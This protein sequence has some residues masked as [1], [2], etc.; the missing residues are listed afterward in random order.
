MVLDGCVSHSQD[1]VST[2]MT[3]SLSYESTLNQ[4]FQW[5]NS[6]TSCAFHGHDLPTIFDSLIDQADQVPVAAP[7]CTGE[8]GSCRT[9]ATGY[10]ILTNVQDSL[11]YQNSTILASLQTWSSL[12]EALLAAVHGNATALSSRI[13]SATDYSGIAIGCQDW[14]RSPASYLEVKSKVLL[15]RTLSPHTRGVSQSLGYQTMCIGWPAPVSNP[16]QLL[17]PLGNLLGK[18][19]VLLVNSFH[20]PQTSMAWAL[21]LKDEMANSVAVY[22]DGSGHTSYVLGGETQAVIDEFLLEGTIPETGT[23]YAN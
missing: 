3:E 18:Q 20:D 10:E 8:T 16:Q 5:C 7:G 23:V 22:R 21:S 9:D 17:D 4:F 12:S 14:Q 6:T 19:E 11:A 1:Q 15:G 2:F 13:G